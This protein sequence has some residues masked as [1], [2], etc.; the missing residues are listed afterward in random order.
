MTMYYG[1]MSG[2]YKWV[3]LQCHRVYRLNLQN[4][5]KRE[6]LYIMLFVDITK[7][8]E[9]G[10]I[11]TPVNIYRE[12]EFELLRPFFGLERSIACDTQPMIK[13]VNVNRKTPSKMRGVESGESFW[14]CAFQ[15]T[16]GGL[17]KTGYRAQKRNKYVAD[18]VT[19]SSTD[20][21]TDHEWALI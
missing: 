14:V 11:H 20:C 4:W 2:L 16:F 5:M 19:L 6:E 13:Y 15:S 3:F 18:Y 21:A 8:W 17:V 10:C 1:I 9:S 7:G 12:R